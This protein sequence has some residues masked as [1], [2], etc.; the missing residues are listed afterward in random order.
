MNDSLTN[1]VFFTPKAKPSFH[2]TSHDS[3]KQILT[4]V[5]SLLQVSVLAHKISKFRLMLEMALEHGDFLC[6]GPTSSREDKL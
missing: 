4:Y 3:C 5:E 1:I 2:F 6:A